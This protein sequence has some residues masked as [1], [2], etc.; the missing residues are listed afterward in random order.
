MQR[1]GFLKSLVGIPAAM[2]VAAHAEPA[3]A[4]VPEPTQPP[5]PT[6]KT[7]TAHFSATAHRIG[8]MYPDGVKEVIMVRASDNVINPFTFE[9]ERRLFID[10]MTMYRAS[11]IRNLTTGE[12][13]KSRFPEIT[14]VPDFA[15]I[16][17]SEHS[18]YHRN[19]NY[20]S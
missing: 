15:G 13:V 18:R 2:A 11:Y 1:R 20:E 19:V 14:D 3:P 9:P 8:I 12:I 5:K 7:V 16:L 17:P 4:P 10:S 6:R